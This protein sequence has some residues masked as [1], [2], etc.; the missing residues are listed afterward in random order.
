MYIY[1]FATFSFD[2]VFRVNASLFKPPSKAD[3][4]LRILLHWFSLFGGSQSKKFA[5]IWSCVC[6]IVYF[7]CNSFPQKPTQIAEN[8]RPS[9]TII[10][11]MLL[12]TS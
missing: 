8:L 1:V 10:A 2:T 6:G 3:H 4:L 5:S 12:Y 9:K 11:W 7:N